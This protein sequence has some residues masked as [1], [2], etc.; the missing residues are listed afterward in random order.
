MRREKSIRHGHI[1]TLH[2]LWARRPLAA[3]RAVVFATL[4]DAPEDEAERKWLEDLI[5]TIVD[6]DH[7]KDGN[8]AKIE[9]AKRLIREQFDGEAPK[10]LDPFAS[11]GA[12]PLEAQRLGCE[13]HAV[14]L[15][16][17][18]HLIEF[19]TLVYPQRYADAKCQDKLTLPITKEG[20][21]LLLRT[22]V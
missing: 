3:C 13:A 21:V 14:E 2:I 6:W 1:S 7:V 18:A 19:C 17:V 15:N 11:G 4:M 16:P 12:I 10:V 20:Y 22:T 8:S 5:A 9:E